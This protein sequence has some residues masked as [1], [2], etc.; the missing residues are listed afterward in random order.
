MVTTIESSFS[1]HSTDE[2]T[3]FRNY[4]LKIIKKTY[5]CNLKNTDSNELE[6]C[7]CLLHYILTKTE[8][9]KV[10]NQDAEIYFC[11]VLYILGNESNTLKS[12]ALSL[13]NFFITNLKVVSIDDETYISQ[14][15]LHFF[16]EENKFL[17]NFFKGN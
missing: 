8:S 5:L 10:I 15:F 1:Q 9:Q 2:S 6:R 16:L 11:Q 4:I 3:H 14:H 12:K 13:F 17:R 7:L